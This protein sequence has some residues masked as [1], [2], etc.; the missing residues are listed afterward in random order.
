MSNFKFINELTE[1]R[2]F[3]GPKDINGMSVQEIAEI[4]FLMFMM[5]EVIR[6][7]KPS[8]AASYATD[9]LKYNTYE[10]MRYAGTDLG[11]LLAVLNNQDT[12]AAQLK[13][14]SGISIPLFQINR[15]L[16]DMGSSSKSSHSDD[17]TFFWR[18][19]DYLKLYS[20]SLLRQLR[21][22]IGNWGDQT[23]A[24]KVQIYNILRREF[25]SRSS[26]ADMY[27]YFKS[28]LRI[29]ESIIPELP[30]FESKADEFEYIRNLNENIAAGKLSMDVWITLLEQHYVNE[31]FIKESIDKNILFKVE[32]LEDFN[33]QNIIVDQK[34]IPVM[35]LLFG[36]NLQVFDINQNS[37]ATCPAEFCTLV[38]Q[39]PNAVFLLVNGK[40]RQFPDN[41][42]SNLSYAKTILIDN[43]DSYDKLRL[44]LKLSLD[45]DLPAIKNENINEAMYYS[46]HIL[47]K[48]FGGDCPVFAVAL[49][50]LTGYP[51]YGLVEYDEDINKTVLIHAYVKAPDGRIIDAIGDE[52]TVEDIL[53]EF[54]NSGEV[55]EVPMT[56]QEVLSIGYDSSNK[57]NLYQALEVA[58][59]VL[60]GLDDI[61]RLDEECGYKA[62]S[63]I[64]DELTEK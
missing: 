31:N 13:T 25:D 37:P 8:W 50:K 22:D 34:Y 38:K 1:A 21:R 42:L 26:S 62:K 6:R 59:Q 47:E 3:F 43:K 48:Y 5:L 2:L 9:T 32:A 58:K 51:I 54:P 45:K 35:I 64:P 46:G 55:E 12:F 16:R 14:T 33:S 30:I 52:S 17:I 15:Y 11:N 24:S 44:M 56:E 49:H 27:L 19:E 29:T 7:V 28:S 20:K 39:L 57:P 41:T 63:V 18:L 40:Q 4:V 23:Y 53:T 10:N 61:N 60:S 36:S